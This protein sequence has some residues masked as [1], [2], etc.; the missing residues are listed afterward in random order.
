VRRAASLWLAL[1]VVA[2]CRVGPAFYALRGGDRAP[3]RLVPQQVP[4]ATTATAISDDGRLL[5]L[6]QDNGAIT[7]WARD[8]RVILRTLRTRS[9]AILALATAGDTAWSIGADGTYCALDLRTLRLRSCGGVGTYGVTAAAIAPAAARLVA[10]CPS[11]DPAEGRPDNGILVVVDLAAERLV[12]TTIAED[13]TS[14]IAITSDGAT[15]GAADWLGVKLLDATLRAGR[16]VEMPAPVMVTALAFTADALLAAGDDGVVRRYAIAD[17]SAQREHPV[18]DAATAIRRLVPLDAARFAAITATDTYVVDPLA[19]AGAPASPLGTTVDALAAAP[20]AGLAVA[21]IGRDVVTWRLDEPARAA[22]EPLP[23]AGRAI[24]AAMIDDRAIW[25]G[26]ADRIARLDRATGAVELRT[27]GGTVRAIGGNAELAIV[28]PGGGAVHQLWSLVGAAPALVRPLPVERAALACKVAGGGCKLVDGETIADAVTGEAVVNVA[29][30]APS[31][32]VISADARRLA[33]AEVPDGVAP[34]QAEGGDFPRPPRVDFYTA[35]VWNTT[36]QR[37]IGALELK[38]PARALALSDDGALLAVVEGSTADQRRDVNRDPRPGP[39]QRL[40]VVDV[41]TGAERHTA[42]LAGDFPVFVEALAFAPDRR[43]LFYATSCHSWDL[44]QGCELRRIELAS[45]ASRVIGRTDDSIR[46]I[47]VS[48]DGDHVVTVGTDGAA[49]IWRVADGASIAMLVAGDDWIV[50]G[51]DGRFDATRGGAALVAAVDGNRAFSLDQLAAVANDPGALLAR[52]G[53][54]RADVRAYFDERHAARAAALGVSL[55]DP[56]RAFAGGPRVT[57]EPVVAA[58]KTVELVGAIESPG[59]ALASYQIWVDQV[60]LLPGDG[61]PIDGTHAAL[62]ET[63]E[64]TAGA[65]RIEVGARSVDGAEALRAVA[66]VHHDDPATGAIYVAAIG[67]STH[68]AAA[69]SALPLASADATA[70][71]DAFA[72]L[73]GARAL[74]AIVGADATAAS[75]ARVRDFFAR[76]SVDDTVV[77]FVAGHGVF[78]AGADGTGDAYLFAPYDFDPAAPAAHGVAYAALEA[79]VAEAPARKRLLLIDSCVSGERD[80][81]TAAELARATAAAGLRA[82]VIAEV[83]DDGPV[84]R[85]SPVG[86]VALGTRLPPEYLLDRD[87][88]IFRSTARGRGVVAIGA[89]RWNERSYEHDAWGHGAFTA[90]LVAALADAATDADADGRVSIDELMRAIGAA[91]AARTAGLQHPTLRADNV[92]AEL[93]LPAA[94]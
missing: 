18:A 19:D 15:I 90:E 87:R 13:R 49:R 31:F 8:Q 25:L 26:T 51:D 56:E 61:A 46:S 84:G 33:R 50:Y 10:L 29:P 11:R 86:R 3:G 30:G 59:A 94:R 71:V 65:N 40:H 2:G 37:R 55:A 32:A 81:A 5:L 17:P 43:A 14:A 62:R 74:P 7:V 39:P 60:P 77:L 91:V 23:G 72:R 80:E 47:S 58:G 69:I 54:G 73:P 52:V 45:G 1:L 21:A 35:T 75:L 24:T 48:P 88:M 22:L 63:I 57:L 27:V 79:L 41:A 28:E 76:A 83:D 53:L 38:G 16:R 9:E 70:V 85:P 67:A 82:R 44:V 66:T 20:G 78:D 36:N 64:L 93:T 4:G 92:D 12:A 89:S 6:G 34:V 42:K 68:R